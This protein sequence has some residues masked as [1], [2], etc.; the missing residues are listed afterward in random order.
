MLENVLNE[1]DRKITLL[2]EKIG[3]E[4]TD[5]QLAFDAVTHSSFC[6]EHKG[7]AVSNE[8]LEFLG[9]SVLSLMTCELLYQTVNED[10]GSLTKIKASLVCEDSLYEYAK[11]LNL[12]E[13][14][15]FGKGEL[16]DG[17]YRSSTLSDAVEAVLGAIYLDGGM[18]KAK[19]FIM[20]Y[21][22]EK[23]SAMSRELPGAR[24]YKTQLQ[25]LVQKNKG[26]KLFYD[27]VG[28]DGPAHDRKFVCR[29]MINSNVM[30][31]A[32]GHS[33]KTAEQAAAK[34]VLSLMGVEV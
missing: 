13:Y 22:R 1:A 3:Y 25:E 29:V 19:K 15:L 4:F 5:R 26:D 16:Q 11:R 30:A 12:G 28:E 27:I 14:L 8:R 34:E 10:E 32:S 24:D 23:L 6:N 33:K 21:I 9:D 7:V 31:T 2:E 17:R 18:A 20:P